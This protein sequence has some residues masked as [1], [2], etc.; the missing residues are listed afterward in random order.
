MHAMVVHFL[1]NF[2]ESFQVTM[3]A[4]YAVYRCECANMTEWA[5]SKLNHI[6]LFFL[7]CLQHVLEE[8]N[9]IVAQNV[10]MNTGFFILSLRLQNDNKS[11]ETWF[12][13]LRLAGW[14]AG[15]LGCVLCILILSFKWEVEKCANGIS[16]LWCQ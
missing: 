12:V 10:N 8:H 11:I 6:C 4:K 5:V 1:L 9:R 16:F 13:W 15:W 3:W 14:L 2:F 7:C